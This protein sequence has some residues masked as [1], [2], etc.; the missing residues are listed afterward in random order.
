MCWW[1]SLYYSYS[2]LFNYVNGIFYHHIAL[3]F[4]NQHTPNTVGVRNRWSGE[5][6]QPRGVLYQRL[7]ESAFGTGIQYPL[8]VV[9]HQGHERTV[10]VKLL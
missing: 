2:Y 7:P 6:S 5:C 8:G 4:P 10:S 3:A 1:N 9:R